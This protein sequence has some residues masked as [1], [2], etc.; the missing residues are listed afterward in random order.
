[1][2]RILVFVTALVMVFVFAGCKE[3]EPV[4]DRKPVIYLYPEQTMEVTVKLDF[5][6]E[7]MKKKCKVLNLLC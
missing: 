6:G 4:L 2:K 3:E 1:M 5:D 7:K